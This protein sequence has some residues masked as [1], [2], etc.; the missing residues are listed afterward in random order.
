MPE[1]LDID[2]SGDQA[3]GL[4]KLFGKRAPRVVA[5][6]SGREPAGRTTLVVQT[7]AALA[8][9]G[10]GVVIVDENPGPDNATAG[11]GLSARGDLMN[12]VAGACSLGEVTVQAAP[13]V[14]IV[15]AA[16]VVR[17]FD[18]SDDARRQ[19]LAGCLAEIQR[20]ASFVLI[21]CAAQLSPLALAARHLAVV[22]AAHGNAI[23]EAYALVKLAA[24]ARGR[25]GSFHVAITRTSSE[26]EAR[27]IFENM[28]RVARE[29]LGVR[30]D[31][32]GATTNPHVDHLA[33]AL[34]TRLPAP[35][36][37]YAERLG[38][39]VPH[40]RPQNSVMV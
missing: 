38:Q 21:D 32:L 16:R 5:F 28:K 18:P 20:G 3:S 12:V 24:A 10:H 29:H 7:A 13:R 8:D 33:D 39:P 22:V 19:R 4:R 36:A 15:P 14:R 34:A 2:L 25:R 6:A 37:A 40:A 35:V 26:S 1:T 27:A 11:F 31:Y 23:T 9:A 30:L 17:E